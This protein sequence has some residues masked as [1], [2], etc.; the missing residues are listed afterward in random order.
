MTFS[1]TLPLKHAVTE[2]FKNLLRLRL[3][4]ILIYSGVLETN[5]SDIWD[6]LGVDVTRLVNWRGRSQTIKELTS[7]TLYWSI[8]PWK[9]RTGSSWTSEKLKFWDWT[10]TRGNWVSITC[11]PTLST[12]FFSKLKTQWVRD[13]LATSSF[14]SGGGWYLVSNCE[15]KPAFS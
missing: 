5:N 12:S 3:I 11:A 13:R 6:S 2:V 4:V 9:R 14:K 15:C 1:T 7:L 8:I 10:D